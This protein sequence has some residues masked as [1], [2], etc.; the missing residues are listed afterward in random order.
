MTEQ[1][2]QIADPWDTVND[3]EYVVFDVE[4]N[5]NVIE[6]TFIDNQMEPKVSPQFGSLQFN[7]NVIETREPGIIKIFSP[8]SQRLMR[9]LKELRPLEGKTIKM[10]RFGEGFATDY[11]IADRTPPKQTQIPD[12]PPAQ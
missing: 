11:D 9:K 5:N 10:E 6:V 8:S 4:K 3:K 7:F 2:G 12:Q 1:N